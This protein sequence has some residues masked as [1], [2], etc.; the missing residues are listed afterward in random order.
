MMTGF[1][2]AAFLPVVFP[3]LRSQA[4]ASEDSVIT[5]LTMPV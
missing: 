5:S 1:T 2:Q 3:E 4:T